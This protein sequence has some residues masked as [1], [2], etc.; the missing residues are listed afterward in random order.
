MQ[1][2]TFH[3]AYV[4]TRA[5][6][7]GGASLHLLDLASGVKQAGHRVTVLAGGSG[8]LMEHLQALDIPGISLKYLKR[9][10][11]PVY[12]VRAVLELRRHL[13]RLKP[14]IVHCHSSKAGVVGR[15]AARSLSSPAVFTAHGWA[16]TEG[17]SARRR[18]LYRL[19][20]RA[21]VP[22]TQQIITVSDY[23]RVLALKNGVG[24]EALITTIHNGIHD[25]AQRRPGTVPALPL[26]LIMVARFEP[27]KQQLKLLHEL[28]Q[29]EPETAVL[30]FIGDGSGLDEAKQAADVLGIRDRVTFSGWRTDIAERLA[31]SDVFVLASEWEGLPL[32]ILEAMRACLPVIASNV[33]GVPETVEDGNTGILVPRNEEHFFADAARFLAEHPELIPTMGKRAGEKYENEFGYNKMLNAT[34]ALYTQILQKP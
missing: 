32:S 10:V 25:V 8:I 30:E 33:G 1:G 7:L 21:M 5:D 19:I 31:A 4:I 26:R 14:D 20:E 22:L 16:F 23:D 6:V 13:A 17:V 18:Q 9:D 15:L 27:P 3:V 12:D 28:A 11:D 29:L 34:L 24:S 2:S